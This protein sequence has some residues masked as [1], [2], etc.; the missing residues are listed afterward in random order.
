MNK[1]HYADNNEWDVVVTDE[2]GNISITPGNGGQPPILPWTSYTGRKS[3]NTVAYTYYG[4]DSVIDFN[5]ELLKQK[6]AM[7]AAGTNNYPNPDGATLAPGNN[8]DNYVNY[9]TT[10]LD[11]GPGST[12]YQPYRPIY[13]TVILDSDYK[14]NHLEETIKQDVFDTWILDNSKYKKLTENEKKIITD[15]YT[16]NTENNKYYLKEEMLNSPQNDPARIELRRLLSTIGYRKIMTS[17]SSGLECIGFTQNAVSYADNN[18]YSHPKLTK[19]QTWEN[20][21]ADGYHWPN[22]GYSWLIWHYNKSSDELLNLVIPGDII[23]TTGHAAII[24]KIEYNGNNRK[25][26]LE[27]IFTIEA[28]GEKYYVNMERKLYNIT[29]HGYNNVYIYR[30]KAKE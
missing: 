30:P 19:P 26:M 25:P 27:K 11:V 14:P 7:V 22:E 13:S 10:T 29:K 28:G 3:Y 24:T 2:G 9:E 20:P 17:Y 23:V 8:W 16:L 12:Q 4:K 5:K 6:A 18:K 15:N 1:W 21:H